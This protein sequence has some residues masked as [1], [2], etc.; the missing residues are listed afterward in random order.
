MK[1]A[2][3][4][5]SC[6][7]IAVA[8]AL[9]LPG[10]AQ[11]APSTFAYG[12]NHSWIVGYEHRGSWGYRGERVPGSLSEAIEEMS[13]NQRILGVG[14]NERA[15]IVVGSQ[16]WRGNSLPDD[17]SDYMRAR[18]R[19]GYQIIDAALTKNNHW[20]VVYRRGNHHRGRWSG[21]DV[22]SAMIDY[23]REAF[24]RNGRLLGVGITLDG[25]WSVSYQEGNRIRYRMI[26][27]PGAAVRYTDELDERWR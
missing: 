17:M 9:F 10:F 2:V 1:R 14:M 21:G 16:Q 22:P 11:A 7:L 18:V 25:G 6:A 3:S 12:P 8:C 19:E 27:V 13:G 24:R 26:N 20:V 15:W 5:R 23:M 4:L